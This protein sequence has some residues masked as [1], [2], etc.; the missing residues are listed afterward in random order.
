VAINIE[1]KQRFKALEDR[2]KALEE[3][4]A[5]KAEPALSWEVPKVEEQV[6]LCP[7]C[8]KKPAHHLHVRAC[9]GP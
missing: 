7:K 8:N 2:L 1:V 3:R 9:K 5:Q 4:V 6:K